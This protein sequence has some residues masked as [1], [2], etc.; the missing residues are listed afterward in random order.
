MVDFCAYS[1]LRYKL[2][3]PK[4]KEKYELATAFRLLEPICFKAANQ[5]DPLGIIG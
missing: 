1:L 5:K 2:G 4:H 3:V